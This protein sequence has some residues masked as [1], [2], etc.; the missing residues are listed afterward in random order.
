MKRIYIITLLLLLNITI[1]AQQVEVTLLNKK[2]GQIIEQANTHWRVLDNAKTQGYAVADYNGKIKIPLK[3]GTKIVF[4]ATCVGFK[5]IQDTI[6]LKQKQTLYTEEDVLSIEQVTV[7]GTRTPHILK[8]APV[9]TQIISANE[10]KNIDAPIITDVLQ[11]EMPGIEMSSHGGVPVMNMMGMETQYSLILIDG[12]RISKS[13]QKTIDYSRI[14]TANIERIEIIRGAG[15]AL[16]GSDAMGGVINIITKNPHK[17]IE[18]SADIKYQQP[19]GKNHTQKDIDNMDDAYAKQFFKNID[20]QNLNANLSVGFKDKGFSS[21]TFF[22]FKT[23]D[24]YKLK[25]T[26][27]V[28]RYYKNGDN[29]QRKNNNYET[30]IN[31]FQDFT[32]NQKFRYKIKKWDFNVSGNYYNHHEYDFVNDASHQLYNSYNATAKNTFYL[33]NNNKFMLIHSFDTY[34]RFNY[35]EKDGNT[36]KKHDNRYNNTKLNYT[37]TLGK[38]VVFAEIEN[39]HQILIADKFAVNELQSRYTNNTVLVLQDEFNLSEQFMIVGGVRI[40]YH[41]TFNTHVSP[42]ATA[43]YTIGKFNLR[44]SYAR[45]FRS[46]DVKELYMDWSHL[47]MFQ[48]KGNTNLKPETSNY[49]SFSVDFLESSHNINTTL[50]ASYNDV[51]NKIDGIWTNNETVFNYVNFSSAKI[52]SIEALVKWQF[53]KNFKIKAGYI[54]LNSKKSADAQ[55]LSTM[56]PMSATAQLDYN[57]AKGKYQLNA[58]ISG[59]ITGNKKLDVLDSKEGSIY[60]GQYYQVRYPMFAIWNITINQYY[61]TH[62]K[63]GLGVKNLLDYTAPIVTFNTTNNPGRKF[64]VSVGYK[65]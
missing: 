25:D 22:N 65:F 58:N 48:I 29:I 62:L 28:I 12:E 31:G 41:S 34:Q 26:K 19:N 46:P 40:G 37:S 53:H 5:P 11:V 18:V 39:F 20:K 54:Y 47:G 43:K 57:I 64:F 42:S 6:V 3:I 63:L 16:Y 56:S 4:T 55:D 23:A 33:N 8:K 2:T 10:L 36:H 35:D 27:G 49:Y 44:L 50:I 30:H 21:L 15:S 59:K 7:T 14:N 45:G 61:G 17:N 52:F 24:A 9:L 1:L 51:K 13:L 38:H 60:N 32:I